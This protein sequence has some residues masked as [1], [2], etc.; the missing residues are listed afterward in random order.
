MSINS[1]FKYPIRRLTELR[2]L[3]NRS[4]YTESTMVIWDNFFT[5]K[6]MSFSCLLNRPQ[7]NHKQNYE[8]TLRIFEGSSLSLHF[9]LHLVYLDFTIVIVYHVKTT[10]KRT[11]LR[12]IHKKQK[13]R[14]NL[15]SCKSWKVSTLLYLD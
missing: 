1:V 14:N 5:D 4:L 7:K 3:I 15:E 8:V 9:H 2:N 12:I 6:R 11:F 10:E 13:S